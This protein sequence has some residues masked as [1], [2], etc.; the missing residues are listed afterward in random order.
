MFL[1]TT[2][3]KFV[4]SGILILFHLQLSI[5]NPNIVFILFDD[6]GVTDMFNPNSSIPAPYLN[7]LVGSGIKFSKVKICF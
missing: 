7:S 5:A 6:V 3:I 4:I 1:F 2:I